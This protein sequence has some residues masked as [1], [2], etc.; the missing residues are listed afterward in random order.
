[1]ILTVE[2]QC[3]H[4]NG[5]WLLWLLLLLLLGQR[6]AC[7]CMAAA[8]AADTSVAGQG[9]CV[10]HFCVHWYA[11]GL[12]EGLRARGLVVLYSSGRCGLHHSHDH[13]WPALYL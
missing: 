2:W 13:K 8:A 11:R 9:K 12:L 4:M 10:K 5:C 1:V 6:E 7:T 3:L